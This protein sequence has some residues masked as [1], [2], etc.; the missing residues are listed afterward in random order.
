MTGSLYVIVTYSNSIFLILSVIKHFQFTITDKD[1]SKEKTHIRDIS[2]AT[3]IINY[4]LVF[5]NQIITLS[6]VL[7]T[8]VSR[9]DRLCF[10]KNNSMNIHY[11]IIMRVALVILDK[12]VF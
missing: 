4:T 5:E 2:R 12:K 9:Y 8:F 10:C 11:E 1:K 6:M 7:S 3:R